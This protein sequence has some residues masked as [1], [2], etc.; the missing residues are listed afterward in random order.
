MKIQLCITLNVGNQVDY[1]EDQ[2]DIE[3][4]LLIAIKH[5]INTQKK[6]PDGRMSHHYFADAYGARAMLAYL[7]YVNK[8]PSSMQKNLDIWNNISLED[9]S[10]C[11]YRF[12][13]MLAERQ[14]ENGALP[15][16]YQEHA[17]GYNVADGGQ[18]VLSV[19]QSLRYIQDETKK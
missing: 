7:E 18:M 14:L 1:F 9:I 15:M 5:L 16:G 10:N 17:S 12:Y 13:D 19:E 2:I 8:N 11:A 3:R 4:A 6:Y